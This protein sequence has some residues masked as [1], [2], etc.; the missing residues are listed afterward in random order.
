V[1]SYCRVLRGGVFVFAR[2]LCR[3][4]TSDTLTDMKETPVLLLQG[5]PT[6]KKTPPH[7]EP[8]VGLPLNTAWHHAPPPRLCLSRN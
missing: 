7:Q 5:Y 6:H 2:Y 1:K 4:I 8:T 3:R